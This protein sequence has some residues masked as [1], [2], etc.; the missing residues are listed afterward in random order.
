MPASNLIEDKQLRQFETKIDP[1]G[2]HQALSRQ[3]ITGNATTLMQE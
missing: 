2:L 3:V 1:L